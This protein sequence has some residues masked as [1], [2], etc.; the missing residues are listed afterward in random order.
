MSR[1]IK[2]QRTPQAEELRRLGI[3][4]KLAAALVGRNPNYVWRVLHGLAHSPR[5][6]KRIDELIDE[7]QSIF[8]DSA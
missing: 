4:F 5:L 8:N 3:P 1:V 6:L 7:H 2:S